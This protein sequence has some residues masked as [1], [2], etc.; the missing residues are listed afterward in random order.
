MKTLRASLQPGLGES[1]RAYRTHIAVTFAI[2][3]GALILQACSGVYRSEFSSSSDETAHYVTALMIRDYVYSGFQEK[4]LAFA[5]AYYDHY[6]KVAFGAWPPLFHVASAI[7]MSVFST[8]RQSILFFMG[9]IAGL[10]SASLYW[11]AEKP[12]GR[13]IA[14]LASA[15]LLLLPLIQ[16]LTS[17][18]MADNL[19]GLFDFWAMLAFG[20]FLDR[21]RTRDITLF[22]VFAT[23]NGLTKPNG[24][25][26]LLL[27]FF[28]VILANRFELLKDRRFWAPFPVIAVAGG[29]FEYISWRFTNQSVE[30]VKLSP[31]AV[32]DQLAGNFREL[33]LVLGVALSLL[34]VLGLLRRYSRRGVDAEQGLWI[35]AAS[36]LLAV[37]VFHS[38]IPQVRGVQDRYLTG[39]IGPAMLFAGAGIRAVWDRIGE[40]RSRSVWKIAAVGGLVAALWL[41]PGLRIP[42][43][44]PLGFR[45]IAA[46]LSLPE[47]RNSVV[48]VSS[49]AF[50]EGLTV[51]ELAMVDQ[52]PEHRILRASKVLSE[53]NWN[54]LDYHLKFKTPASIVA[55]LD[56]ESV[57]FVILDFTP[58]LPRQPHHALLIEAIESAPERWRL[59]GVFPQDRKSERP[60]PPIRVY[61]RTH[62]SPAPPTAGLARPS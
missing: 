21:G 24:V 29:P 54:G 60:L 18:I 25:A 4:P 57:E 52:R 19:I 20:S 53:S 12:L 41:S 56:A 32:V 50:G 49:E 11:A 37:I 6:P 2:I 31:L 3:A 36:L 30:K 43:K 40:S 1:L 15:L 51:S 14:G 10:W 61:Q 28:A 46:R 9:L 45:E 35:A 48:L 13:S 27:P 44:H 5:R 26:L 39:A 55:F 42:D 23:L 34:L 16:D 58:G 7:W 22:T 8:S 62:F 33:F 47:N 17:S 59:F 38:L